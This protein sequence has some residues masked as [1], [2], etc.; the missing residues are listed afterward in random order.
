MS[1]P[2]LHLSSAIELSGRIRARELSPVELMRATL[3]RIAAV[4][5]RLNAFVSMRP[6]NELLTAAKQVETRLMRGDD[7]GPLAGLPLGVKNLFKDHRP[8]RPWDKEW[9]AL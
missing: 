1:T 2:D 4:N 6:A 7:V 8:A 9:P 5:P 3:D